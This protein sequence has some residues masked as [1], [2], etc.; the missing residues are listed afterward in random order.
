MVRDK[1]LVIFILATL[2]LLSLSS[3]SQKEDKPTVNNPTYSAHILPV[4]V[5]REVRPSSIFKLH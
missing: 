2:I 5:Y 3:C 1:K 4:R